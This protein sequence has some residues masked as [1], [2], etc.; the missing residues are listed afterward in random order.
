MDFEI[1]ES[2]PVRIIPLFERCLVP[3]ALY[4][5]M[6]CQYGLFMEN[7]VQNVMEGKYRVTEKEDSVDSDGAEKKCGTEMNVDKQVS[8]NDTK[9]KEC[10]D[11]MKAPEVSTNEKIVFSINDSDKELVDEGI[12]SDV[13]S[14]GDTMVRG[15]AA[16]SGSQSLPPEHTDSNSENKNDVDC[17]NNSDSQTELSTEETQTLENKSEGKKGEC[18]EPHE[19]VVIEPPTLEQVKS[20]LCKD[21]SLNEHVL[22]CPA[23]TPEWIKSGVSWEDVRHIYRRGAWIHCPSKP[24]LLMQ[25]AEFEESQ[26]KESGRRAVTTIPNQ[27]MMR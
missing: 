9:E 2:D 3:C 14:D 25:W 1:N 20:E 21:L 18:A 6:W 26:G 22:R 10:K 13:T 4:E 23:L 17:P 19:Q 15:S 24:V 5:D 8:E 16:A 12:V 27:W 7:H 11:A